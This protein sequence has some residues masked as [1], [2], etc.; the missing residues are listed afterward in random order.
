MAKK[1][2]LLISH[3]G[4]D[5]QSLYS[6]LDKNPRIQGEF[7]QL[8]LKHADEV[9]DITKQNH[10]DNSTAS[11]YMI[12]MLV[13][14]SLASKELCKV[15]KFV[16]LIRPALHTLNSI[17]ELNIFDPQ[18]A[19]D[20]YM[21]RLRKISAIAKETPGSVFLTWDDLCRNEGFNL[22]E[23]YLNLKTPLGKIEVPEPGASVV[24]Q[25]IIDK[26]QEV[27]ERHL[28]YMKTLDLQFIH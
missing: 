8:T 14:F 5:Y 28:R 25:S 16:H 4:S 24:H 2:L 26:G 20:Y 6:L 23:E 13:N 7:K 10:K 12:P 1:V 18:T 19:L 15:C 11:I 22:L 27:Y 17:V 9:I 21:F 3:H